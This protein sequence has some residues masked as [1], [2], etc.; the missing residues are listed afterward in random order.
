MKVKNGYKIEKNGWKYI[1]I[2]GKPYE[3]GYAHGELLSKEIKEGI[4]MLKFSLYDS[5]GLPFDFFIEVSNFFFKTKIQENYPELMEELKG[6]LNGANKHGAG[7]TLDELILWNNAASLDY[8]LSKL[9]EYL[10]DIPELERKYGNILKNLSTGAQEGGSKDKCSAFIAVGEYTND[11]KICCAHN[12]FDGYLEGQFFYCII[13]SNPTKGNRMIYQGAP[14]YISSQTD[15]FVTSAGIIGTETTIGGF[16]S[17]KYRDPIVCR[18]RHAM[19]YGK[20]LDDY[21]EILTNN[22]SGDYA[23]S[24]LFGDI[25]TNEIMRIE[26]GVEYVNVER[27]KNGYFIGF[28]AAYDPRIRN[29]ECINTGFDDIRRHQGARK[30]RLEQLME[31]NKGKIDTNIAKEIIADHYDVYLNKINPSSRTCCSHYDLDD[32]AFMS[33]SDRPKPY[34]PRGALDGAVCDSS[35]A[36]NMSFIMRWGSSCGI[37]FDKEDFVKRNAQWK[38]FGPYLHDRQS[39]PWTLFKSNEKYIFQNKTNKINKINKTTRNKTTRNK[40][41]I[42]KTTINKTTRNKT[43]RNKTTRNEI[44]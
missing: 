23:N 12:S 44:K 37:A 25:K 41:T 38:R 1:S 27:T 43:T 3:L 21:V 36:K 35:L 6:I 10:N 40:T 34:E 26:L 28:N 39:Q 2:K 13:D 29:L 14:G 24:W 32:R 22:N 33:Q 5:H 20:N 16:I 17:Y 11:G 15:F 8:P 7:I 19:Q 42:N 30:V 18:I 9:E 4:N 31:Q